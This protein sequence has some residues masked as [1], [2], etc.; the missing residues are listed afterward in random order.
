MLRGTIGGF[1]VPGCFIMVTLPHAPSPTWDR[2]GALQSP[3]AA[4]PAGDL[5]AIF[6]AVTWTSHPPELTPPDP[7]RAL[8]ED[9]T[10]IKYWDPPTPRSHVI[11]TYIWDPAQ[12]T[13]P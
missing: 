5:A 10:T 4:V 1:V 9:T 7:R 13:H 3:G 2:M 11:D 12:P 8:P 6:A